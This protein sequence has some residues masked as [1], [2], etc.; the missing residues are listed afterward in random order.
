MSERIRGGHLERAAVVYVRQ[1]SAGQLRRHAESTRLQLGL[2]G[3]AREL[4]WH[5]STIISD[6]LGVSAA[7]YADRPGFQRLVTDVSL[8]QVGIILCVEASRLSRNSKDWAQLFELCGHLDTLVADTDQVYDLSIANDRLLLGIKGSVSEY[9]LALLRQRSRESTEAKAKRGEFRLPLP[10]GLCWD[11][12]KVEMVPD[13][14]I[15]QAL[16]LV[17]EKF[18]Q[19]GSCR[20][21][22][23]WLSEHDISLPTKGFPGTGPV[24]WCSPTYSLVIGIVRNP[25]YAGAYA[26]GRT[27]PKQEVVDGQLQKTRVHKPMSEW[28]VLI[29]DHHPGYISW[30]QFEQNQ[31]ALAENA[32]MTRTRGRKSAR[33]GKLL[34]AGLLRCRRC[35]HMLHVS[36]GRN[37]DGRYECRQMNK[38]TAAPRCIGFVARRIDA[39]VREQVLTAVQGPALKAAVEAIATAAQHDARERHAVEL[40]LQQ[41][42]YEAGLAQRRYEAVDPAQRLVAA[43]LEAR[44]NAAL[45]TVVTQEHRLA[46]MEERSREAP[47]VKPAL[48]TSL[49]QDMA[50]VWDSTDAMA[51]KQRIVRVLVQE[52]VADVDE[53]QH[54]VVLLIHWVGGRHSEIRVNRPRTGQ[55]GNATSKQADDIVRCMAGQWPDAQIAGTLN[56]LGLRTGVGNTWTAA[57]VLSVRKRLRLVDFDPAKAKP[58]LTLNQA[59]DKLNVGPWVIRRL[60]KLGVLEATHPFLG[61]PWRIDPELLEQKRVKQVVAAVVARRIRPGSE[62]A[63]Q[64]NLE[65]PST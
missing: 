20:Q 34:L 9:E 24:R 61:A 29:R 41:A 3:R 15:Q 28:R 25:T 33:G 63:H 22:L 2:T 13:Q 59:A 16:R 14:R 50:A 4:G 12:G 57:R 30:E 27:A 62:A 38:A 7:G 6:D 48:L 43:E 8:R 36:Y 40:E 42:R 46:K 35:G 31:H 37:H 23:M 45:E 11:H 65:I 5:E 1:S 58:M 10:V 52:I 26:Y 17:F 49:A 39:A 64:L 32:F 53:A 19:L 60:V 21:V 55:H 51:L 18:S 44:W 54:E 56:R 47:S